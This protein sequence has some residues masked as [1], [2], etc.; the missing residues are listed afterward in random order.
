MTEGSF[1]LSPISHAFCDIQRTVAEVE[2]CTIANGDD[3]TAG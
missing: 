3:R 2:R 1:P